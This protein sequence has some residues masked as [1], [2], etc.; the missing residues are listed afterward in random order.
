MS[1]SATNRTPDPVV[2][3][4][5]D[6]SAIERLDDTLEVQ[7]VHKAN[8]RLMPG[9]LAMVALGG[10]GSRAAQEAYVEELEA[11]WWNDP[12]TTHQDRP[13]V[14][15]LNDEDDTWEPPLQTLLFWSEELRARY[16]Y[17]IEGRRITVQTEAAFLRWALEAMWREEPRWDDFA[18]DVEVARSRL[19]ATL[20]AGVRPVA[21]GVSCM[22]D[23][24]RGA[25]LIRKTVPARGPKGEKTWRLTDWHCP[26]CKRSWSEEDYARNVY[27]AIERQHW[28]VLDTETWCTVDRAARKVGRPEGTVRVWV[29]RGEVSALCLT[30]S[31]IGRTTFVLLDDVVA[32][33]QLAKKRHAEWLAAR[34]RRRMTGV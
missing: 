15:H 11:R 8:D 28:L 4:A 27:G 22:Y 21:R 34:K 20:A 7:V 25:R 13:D 1:E 26:K 12:A 2:K 14:S 16:G 29:S 24:C 9:G 23:E 30:E 31:A 10:V 33:D 17:P 6:L 32:R 19:E 18:K 3:V 5:Q